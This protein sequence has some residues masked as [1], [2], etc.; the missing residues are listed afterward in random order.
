[1]PERKFPIAYSIVRM[2]EFTMRV[3]SAVPAAVAALREISPTPSHALDVYAWFEDGSAETV[4]FDSLVSADGQHWIGT[5][6]ATELEQSLFPS[7]MR[8]RVTDL[9]RR[10]PEADYWERWVLRLCEALLAQVDEAL[11]GIPVEEAGLQ[12]ITV[13]EWHDMPTH[14][15]LLDG[16]PIPKWW[17]IITEAARR[18]GF[19][20]LNDYLQRAGTDERQADMARRR[21]E[22]RARPFTPSPVPFGSSNEE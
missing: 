14:I 20:D 7:T 13:A 16:R 1:V 22:L 3:T 17:G 2:G 10:H 8:E 5:N 11:R 15:E 9:M 12:E 21:A 18:L 6:A 4:P 19:V